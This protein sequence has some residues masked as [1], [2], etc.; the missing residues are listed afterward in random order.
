MTESEQGID[1][2]AR[3]LRPF[4]MLGLE[5]IK[6]TTTIFRDYRENQNCDIIKQGISR[7]F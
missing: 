2:M 5:R 4:R 6:A 1:K 3:H 7:S